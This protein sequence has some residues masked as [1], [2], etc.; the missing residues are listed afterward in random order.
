MGKYLE[1]DKFLKWTLILS[2]IKIWKKLDV[3]FR[4][5]HLL[6]ISYF[7][8][9]INFPYELTFIGTSIDSFDCS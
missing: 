1:L 8:S 7:K 2:K 9:K 6:W 5:I 4:F 3:C